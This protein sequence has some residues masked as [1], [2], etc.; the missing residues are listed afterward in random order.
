MLGIVLNH[1]ASGSANALKIFGDV[2]KV[3]AATLFG[4]NPAP[5]GGLTHSGV[6]L[7][8]STDGSQITL[9]LVNGQV[10]LW[11]FGEHS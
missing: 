8:R 11:N 10:F 4:T 5:Q 1:I 2:S 7:K 3:K 9:E 6:H